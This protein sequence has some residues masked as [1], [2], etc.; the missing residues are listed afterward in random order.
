MSPQSLQ[1]NSMVERLKEQNERLKAELEMLTTKLEDFVAKAKLKKHQKLEKKR[2]GLEEDNEIIKSKKQELS[3]LQSK[4]KAY[5]KEI[6]NLRRQL[7][8][9][10]NI[11]KITSLEDEVKD[12]ERILKQLQG[13]NKS[14]Q[15]VQKEQEKA[16]NGLKK[17]YALD[18][19]I[20]ELNADLKKAK[21]KLR[22]VW[23]Y[24]TV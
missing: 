5:N 9:S 7:E 17:D 6:T 3:K 19:K 12:K 4:I 2:K 20:S 22:K 10:Y 18:E 21:E 1:K 23:S 11:D 15:S 16:L 24:L 13:E 8:G 14:L